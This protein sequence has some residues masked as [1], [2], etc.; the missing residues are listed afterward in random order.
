MAAE[1][2]VSSLQVSK[3]RCFCTMIRNFWDMLLP[4]CMQNIGSMMY[5][6]IDICHLELT[7]WLQ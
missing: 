7:Q 3:L 2:A 5:I 6:T 1:L 4:F